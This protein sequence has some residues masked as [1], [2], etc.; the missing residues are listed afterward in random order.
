MMIK[1]ISYERK[2]NPL[3]EENPRNRYMSFVVEKNQTCLVEVTLVLFIAPEVS[4][5]KKEEKV[6]ISTKYLCLIRIK[7][8]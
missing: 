6:H 2:N 1:S 5:F 3:L 4:H 7:Y 8:L